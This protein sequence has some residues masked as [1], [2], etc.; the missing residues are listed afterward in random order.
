MNLLYFSLGAAAAADSWVNKVIKMGS[1]LWC[2]YVFG[3]PEVQRIG[4]ISITF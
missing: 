1:K 2:N 3:W 4:A